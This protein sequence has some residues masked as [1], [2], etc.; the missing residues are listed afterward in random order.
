MNQARKFGCL[1]ILWLIACSKLGAQ[2]TAPPARGKA[3]PSS[4]PTFKVDVDLVLVEVGVHDEHGRAAGNL[5][6]EDFHV[7]EDGKE[8]QILAF[9]H[10]ELP[11]A[12]ALVIDNSSSIAAALEELRSGALDTLALL[13]P[14]DQVAI[15]SFGEKP[16]MEEGL[17]SDHQALSVDLWALSPYGGT[18]IDGALYEAATYLGR[19]APES[20]RAVILVSDNEPS[21]EQTSDVPQVVRAAQQSGTPIYSIKVGFLQH[22]RTYFLTHSESR[23]KDV[24]KICQQT[25]G[26]MIDTRNGISVS[27]AMETIL[28]WLKQGYTLGYSPTNRRQDGSYRNIE[29][30]LGNRGEA[31]KRK[32]NVY[33]RQGYY[34][35]TTN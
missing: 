15:F 11:L 5:Q 13:K 4:A 19:M 24:E 35:P 30:H 27:A 25:G 32:Y 16:E 6:Q 31:H 17:T 3:S 34:A 22:S 26:E 29:V 18:D 20:R 10:E 7:F 8:Q 21:E 12:V 2:V 23:L 28:T 1:A 14:D 33:A 9:S